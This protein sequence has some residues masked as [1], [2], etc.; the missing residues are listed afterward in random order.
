MRLVFSGPSDI[1]TLFILPLSPGSLLFELLLWKFFCV[2]YLLLFPIFVY[3]SRSPSFLPLLHNSLLP[4]PGHD[5]QRHLLRISQDRHL[6]FPKLTHLLYLIQMLQI[7]FPISSPQK[8][9]I[10]RLAG[11]QVRGN[12]NRLEMEILVSTVSEIE[13]LGCSGEACD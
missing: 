10:R 2:F 9:H 13:S 1:T 3:T 6:H 7:M 11:V 5:P 8:S 12:L 4:V